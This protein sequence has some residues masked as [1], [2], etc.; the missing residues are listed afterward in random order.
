[1]GIRGGTGD[2]DAGK[3][4]GKGFGGGGGGK[5]FGG[6]GKGFGGGGGYKGGDR[7]FDGGKGFGGGGK[8]KG[9][10]S[11]Y[12]IYVGGLSY[13][14]TNDSL[15]RCFEEAGEVIYAGVM[16]DRDTGRSRGCGKVE[17]ATADAMDY[18]IA[19]FNQTELDGRRIN[20]RQF[21]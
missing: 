17:F 8:G 5:G 10:S 1:M 20:V 12:K 21:T 11:G 13:D 9:K 2:L 18:A 6:G 7:G 16:T 19:E 14:T 15:R 4:G 3:G